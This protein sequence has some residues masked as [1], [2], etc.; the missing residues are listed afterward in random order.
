MSLKHTII[1]CAL[2]L[3]TTCLLK[4][5]NFNEDVHPNK[6]LSSFPKQIGEWHGKEQRFESE[7]YK[8]LGVDDSF[9]ATYFAADGQQ[10][11]LYVG[12][13]QS[14]REGDIIHSPKNCMPGSG[15]NIINSSI[16]KLEAPGTAHKDLKVIKFKLRNGIQEQIALYWYQSR[17]R[18]ISSEYM[19]KIYLVLDSI[20][21]RRTDGSFVRLIAP[22]QNG[23]EA[24]ATAAIKRFAAEIFPI[25]NE[26]LPT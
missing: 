6:P 24:Q 12:F 16:E 10:V 17:G 11:Q 5:V 21:R 8:I 13:Y 22:I 23:N 2:M 15:W 26:Y 25:L 1:A 14:Q 19:Q 20:T 18:I 3:S 9:L 7:I 4:F